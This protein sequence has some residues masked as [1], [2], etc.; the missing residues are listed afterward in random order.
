MAETRVLSFTNPATGEQFGQVPM[1]TSEDIRQ[2]YADLRQR[3]PEWSSKPVQERARILGKL[4][5]VLIDSADEITAVLNRDTG[6]SRQ[7]AL[8][9]L[10]MTVD[11]LRVNRR[12]AARWL[13]RVPVP[14]GYYMFKRC[15]YEPRPYGVVLVISPWNYPFYLAMPPVISALLAGNTVILKP[16]EVTGAT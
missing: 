1:A 8:I 15:Y 14:R 5:E 11:L 9:E 6:K 7:D 12:Y 2:A 10:W 16:S 13:K 3:F 4:Q